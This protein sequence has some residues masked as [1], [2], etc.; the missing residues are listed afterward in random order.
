[1]LRTWPARKARSS[2]GRV[3][4]LDERVRFELV[5]VVVL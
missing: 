2:R 3:L 5:V 1:M 4:I